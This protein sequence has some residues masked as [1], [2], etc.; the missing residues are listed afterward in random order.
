MS[1][2]GASK[3]AT[4]SLLTSQGAATLTHQTISDAQE[5]GPQSNAPVSTSEMKSFAVL[6]LSCAEAIKSPNTSVT[7]G[8]TW[9]NVATY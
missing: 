7:N 4:A 5:P 3:S 6:N 2:M 1:F 8:K 9:D